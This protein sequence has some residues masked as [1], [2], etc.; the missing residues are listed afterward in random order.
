MILNKQVFWTF[1]Q[2]LF[3]VNL[4]IILTRSTP[5]FSIGTVLNEDSK[6]KPVRTI[7]AKSTQDIK[8]P[9]PKWKAMRSGLVLPSSFGNTGGHSDSC[10]CGK[11]KV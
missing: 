2:L 3:L 4:F 7:T 6:T 10:S 5:E 1:R 8:S 9:A 11:C